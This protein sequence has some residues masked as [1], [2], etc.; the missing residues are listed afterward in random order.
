MRFEGLGVSPLARVTCAS[1]MERRT[2]EA[3]MSRQNHL[4]NDREGVVA[5]GLVECQA[6]WSN[7]DGC[8]VRDAPVFFSGYGHMYNALY[9]FSTWR[10]E[11]ALT[12]KELNSS[13]T[14]ERCGEDE[15]GGGGG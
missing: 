2:T 4:L 7:V 13:R 9:C 14:R 6:A 3:E 10:K 11:A 5:V 15:G 8:R 1:Q 12:F